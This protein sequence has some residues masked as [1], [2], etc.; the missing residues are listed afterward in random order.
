MS[1]PVHRLA[2]PLTTAAVCPEP[3]T[4][5]VH[6]RSQMNEQVDVGR[7]FETLEQLRLNLILKSKA[8]GFTQRFW[9]RISLSEIVSGCRA[10]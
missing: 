1:I 9:G 10:T 6:V 3:V 2:G 8:A 4:G 5:L 7:A